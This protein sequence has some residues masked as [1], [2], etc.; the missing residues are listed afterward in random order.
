MELVERIDRR[1]LQ[2]LQAKKLRRLV[3]SAWTDIPFYRRHW[4]AAG[5]RPDAIRTLDDARRL[6]VMTREDFEADLAACPPF[7]TFQGPTPAARVHASSGTSGQTRP[8]SFSSA[9]CSTIADLSARRLRAQ[10]VGP[11]DRV[12][13]ALPYSLYIGGSIAIEGAMRAGATVIPTGTGAMTP[14]DRQVELIR[15][16]QVTVLCTTPSYALHLYDVARGDGATLASDFAVRVVYATAEQMTEETRHL[17]DE[18]WRCRTFNN[19]G[20]V[21]AAACCY[22]CEC[23][24]GWHISEDSYLV[25]IL[26][27]KTYEPVP[28]GGDGAVV[29]TSLSKEAAPFIRCR[30]GDLAALWDEPCGCGRTFARMSPLKGRLDDMIKLRGVNFFPAAVELAL[31]EVPDVG[32]EWRMTVDYPR[33][34][35]LIEVEPFGSDVGAGDGRAKLAAAVASHVRD[36][37][38]VRPEVQVLGRGELLA[39]RGETLVKVRRVVV[40]R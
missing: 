24:R 5:V 35:L 2:G 15:R 22:E 28:P 13:V 6:P 3:A 39:E 38:G 34:L 19:Y 33:Q 12:L 23:R 14:S 27:P 17:I 37:L 25:E 9:D 29:I 10:G 40:R 4:E 18:R 1:D 20:T 16:W 11:G 31:R 32:S 8:V 26:D 21:E 7:G 36:R 30:V